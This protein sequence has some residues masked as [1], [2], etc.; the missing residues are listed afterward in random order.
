MKHGLKIQGIDNSMIYSDVTSGSR[1]TGPVFPFFPSN[2][3]FLDFEL[4]STNILFKIFEL[5]FL[6]LSSISLKQICMVFIGIYIYPKVSTMHALHK[7][8]FSCI[9]S[10]Y[11]EPAVNDSLI[12]SVIIIMN[13]VLELLKT[14][15]NKSHKEPSSCPDK[16]IPKGHLQLNAMRLAD[17]FSD[18]SNFRS[19]ITTHIVRS[20][21][22]C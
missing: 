6:S 7:W 21:H 20:L 2:I 4:S 17:V 13:Q 12:G 14:L 8:S 15:F 22:Y 10:I 3:F 5:Q 18:D 16:D 9:F 11:F 1:N 19:Y